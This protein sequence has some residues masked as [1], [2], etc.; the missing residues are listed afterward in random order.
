MAN[1]SL[2]Q[3]NEIEKIGYVCNTE[4]LSR[5]QCCRGKAMNIIFAVCVCVCSLS[6][7]GGEERRIQSFGGETLGEKIDWKTQA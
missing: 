7:Y 6:T 2:R 5:N 4:P 3:I 1:R